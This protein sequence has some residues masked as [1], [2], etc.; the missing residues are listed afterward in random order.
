M[1]EICTTYL[2]DNPS[3]LGNGHVVEVNKT[4]L[5]HAKYHL[6]VHRKETV[7]VFG[8]IET[9]TSQVVVEIVPNKSRAVL[10]PI[11]QQEKREN[12]SASRNA[13]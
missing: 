8:M 7:T 3:M 1:H 5:S 2:C 11:I 10:L 9:D 6:G 4:F 13:E 12:K